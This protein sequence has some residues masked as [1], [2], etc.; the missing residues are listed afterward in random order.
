MK[1]VSAR[2]YVIGP[3]D[4]PSVP[5]LIQAPEISN[6]LRKSGEAPKSKTELHFSKT[7]LADPVDKPILVAGR[8]Q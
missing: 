2:K 4:E 1:H 3:V 5:V 6:K 7:E 8:S